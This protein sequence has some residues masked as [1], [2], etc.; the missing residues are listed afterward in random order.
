MTPPPSRVRHGV[1]AFAVALAV[2]TYVDRVAI[3]VAAPFISTDLALSKTQMAWA[4]AAFGWAYAVF[5]IPG[6]WL[7]DKIGP[8]RVLLRI[9]LWW[10]AFT[11]ATS[12]A[13]NAASLIA[14][15]ALFGAGEAGAFPNLTRVLTTWLPVRER[16]RAQATV[17]LATRVSGAFTPLLV[18]TLIGLLGWRRTF[19]ILGLLGAIWAV[20][21][22]LWYRDAP[23]EHPGVNAA[24]LALLPPPSETA[25]AHSGVPWRLIFSTP[26]VWLL[27]I[28]YMCLAY[29]WWFYINWLPTYL[30]ES[31]GTTLRMG[32]LLA[33]LP[34]LLGGLGCIVSAGVIPRLARSLGSVA[35]ARRA[36]AITG[37]VGASA[38]IFIFTGIEDPRRAMIV[39]GFAGFFNDFVM[40][41]AWAG[42]MDIGG[43]YAG[44]VAGAMNMMGSIAGASSV[45][46]VGYLLAW[47]G[48]WTIT[49]YVSAAIYLIGAFCWL[50]LD[51]HTPLRQAPVHARQAA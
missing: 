32:A 51:S 8:R 28:Q 9:V 10:S 20:F 26:A 38:C 6:G 30:R 1:T 14:T 39:L 17:W 45:L 15:R 36:V 22:Y 43:R 42:T 29:G 16:E 18:A 50:F 34:L 2:I 27:S 12:F 5:E 11:A 33:G 44:T 25:I 31:R 7:G 37:F 24:E 21:F 4:L 41:A 48:N 40:P 13:W 47:T 19:E 3:S 23:S 46:V 49:F 35:A